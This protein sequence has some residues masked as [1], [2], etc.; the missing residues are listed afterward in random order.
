MSISKNRFQS[1]LAVG[2][3]RAEI[4]ELENLKTTKEAAA[5][6]K[7]SET[8]LRQLTSEGKIPYFKF[9]RQNRYQMKDLIKLI[10]PGNQGV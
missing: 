10:Q 6:L 9:G 7:L 8:Y 5:F 3:E 4:K 2:S 1:K